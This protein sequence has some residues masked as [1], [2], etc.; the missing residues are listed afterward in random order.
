MIYE[1]GYLEYILDNIKFRYRYIF[2]YFK[3]DMI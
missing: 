3:V 1:D 2:F